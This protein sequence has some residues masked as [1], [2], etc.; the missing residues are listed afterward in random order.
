MKDTNIC[1]I[2][3]QVFI[4]YGNNPEPV[5]KRGRCCDLCN[6]NKVIPARLKQINKHKE[7]R[8]NAE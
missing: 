3:R 4:G 6:Y 2:C 7:D 5:K 8:H 1:C